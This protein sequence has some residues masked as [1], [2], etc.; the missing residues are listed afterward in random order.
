MVP[1]TMVVTLR[2]ALAS[3]CRIAAVLAAAQAGGVGRVAAYAG[4]DRGTCRLRL[5][6]ARQVQRIAA[7]FH[8]GAVEQAVGGGRDEV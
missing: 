5:A 2:P 1:S 8:D 6:Q 4:R 3:V 7:A